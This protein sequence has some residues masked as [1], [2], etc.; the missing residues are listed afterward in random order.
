M[1]LIA[2]AEANAEIANCLY[3]NEKTGNI[4]TQASGG[5]VHSRRQAA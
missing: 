3:E 4:T 5:H 2:V 1:S